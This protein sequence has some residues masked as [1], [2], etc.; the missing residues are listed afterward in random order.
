MTHIYSGGYDSGH[1]DF[2]VYANSTWYDDLLEAS[3]LA[4]NGISS[5]VTLTR[6]G[7]PSDGAYEM[8]VYESPSP[9]ASPSSFGK[10]VLKSGGQYGTEVTSYQTYDYAEIQ[11]YYNNIVNYYNNGLASSFIIGDSTTYLRAN[12]KHEIGHALSLIHTDVPNVE[13]SH[14]Y[15]DSNILIPLIMNQGAKLGPEINAADKAH[16]KMKWGA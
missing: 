10:T 8:G 7:T 16:I 4:W 11:T 15:I 3:A 14:S 13:I 5:N 6:T 2:F 12:A 1:I 9:S